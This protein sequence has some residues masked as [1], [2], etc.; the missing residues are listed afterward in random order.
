VV[1]VLGVTVILSFAAAPAGPDEPAAPASPTPAAPPASR[2][3]Y[4]E[5]G[6]SELV[7]IET[8]VT[9]GMG[10]PVR[11]LTKDDF[12]LEVG[13][14]RRSILSVDYH[15]FEPGAESVAVDIAAP[16]AGARARPATWPRR[17]VLFFEDNTSSP[18]GMTAARQA[19][20]RFLESGLAA[21]DEVA[22][23]SY[24]LRLRYLQ[25]FT[26]DRALLRQAVAA[27]L[28]DSVRI[29][30]FW[31]EV[32][33][34][35]QEFSRNLHPMTA[36][37]ICERQKVRLAGALE[38]VKRLVASLAEW[39]GY[40]AVVFM[41]NGI[42]ESPMEDAWKMFAKR[43]LM[44][45]G[46]A[47]PFFAMRCTLADEIKDL[48]RAASA[49]G[50]TI[51]TV[52]TWGL[53][54][55]GAHD[56]ATVSDRSNSLRTLALN[57]AG[58][59]TTTND[60]L[61]ALGTIDAA[62]RAYYVLSYVPQ[63]PADGRYHHVVVR[64]RKKGVQL[65]YRRGFTRLPPDEA[66][67]R[68]IESAYLFPEM[69]ADL[70]LD[71]TVAPGPRDR[72]AGAVDLVL[73]VPLERILFLP[74]QDHAVARFSV[75]FVAI[76]ETQ[77]KTLATTRTMSIRRPA[78]DTRLTGVDV[79]C[80]ARLPS[81]SQAITAVLTDEQSGVTGGVRE[82]LTGAASGEAM[83]FG[84]SLYSLAER[85]LWIEVSPEDLNGKD[86]P[87]PADYDIG[88]SLKNTFAAG[89]PIVAG[90]RFA[91]GNRALPGS[92]SVE[93]RRGDELVR[94]RSVEP[95][96]EEFAGPIKVRLPVEGL[97][98]GE[99]VVSVRA[100]LAD[101]DATIGLRKLRIVEAPGVE[102]QLN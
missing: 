65:R 47:K 16:D 22:L 74:E 80:R 79:Y 53:T 100:I 67:Q 98:P 76:D 30:D 45:P 56:Q 18:I 57:T 23:A 10:R 17:I 7:L 5:K 14:Y 12:I 9:D 71:L 70:G 4:I 99:Y 81:T 84:L 21:S 40:K 64:C 15:E 25:S 95:S 93:M 54:A 83:A 33:V 85:S 89:E 59:S 102:S 92:F 62:T 38:A 68:A 27:S 26:T 96:P 60:L 66:R 20:G 41:G 36:Q 46:S 6:L 34:Q 88:P 29:S 49:A 24:D 77:R 69:S 43:E 44:H 101:G 63:E 42:P 91:P 35:W 73:H 11:G 86:D 87:A 50:V 78:N 72:S 90:F 13:S 3:G 51:H 48:S 52:Q 61:G 31:Q 58:V 2:T 28:E 19:A 1:A 97:A 82:R 37:A 94:S 8:H 32:A 39:R 75:G 55:G